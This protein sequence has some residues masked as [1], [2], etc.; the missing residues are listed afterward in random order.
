MK[1]RVL[2]GVIVHHDGAVCEGGAILDGDC[3]HLVDG[4]LA[5]EVKDKPKPKAKPKA[6]AKAKSND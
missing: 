2:P 3:Q 4:C 1:V 6:K 5:E